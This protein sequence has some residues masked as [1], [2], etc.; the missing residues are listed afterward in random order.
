MSAE[1]SLRGLSVRMVRRPIERAK[2]L[3]AVVLEP[4]F[5]GRKPKENLTI[6]IS[7]ILGVLDHVDSLI[8]QVELASAMAI[9]KADI[10]TLSANVADLR[11]D[12]DRLMHVQVTVEDETHWSRPEVE[13]VLLATRSGEM[14]A[15]APTHDLL[16]KAKAM[17]TDACPVVRIG[18]DGLIQCECDDDGDAHYD[19][20]PLHRNNTASYAYA[21][22]H[23]QL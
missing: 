9:D 12:L 14:V 3:G 4:K 8:E 19:D 6:Y 20:C 5:Q 22:N 18:T 15:V 13:G 2:H 10:S 7:D 1:D 16:A 21:R 11:R 23:G 17:C